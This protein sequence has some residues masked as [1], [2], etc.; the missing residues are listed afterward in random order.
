[1]KN[2]FS[3]T[4]KTDNPYFTFT[5]GD[6]EYKVLKLYNAP[7]KAVK[8]PFARAFVLVTTPMTGPGGDMG[9]EYVKNVPG[10]K[11]ALVEFMKEAA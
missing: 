4:R 7:D 10:L 11:A 6:W 2:P 1:M 5:M 3:K 8:D 9:D